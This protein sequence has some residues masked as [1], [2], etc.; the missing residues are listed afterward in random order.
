MSA[1][2]IPSLPLLAEL[3]FNPVLF[4]SPL[5]F[6]RTHTQAHT[7][8]LCTL[9]SALR[10]DRHPLASTLICFAS[11]F[12]KWRERKWCG[13]RGLCER[14]R[15]RGGGESCRRRAEGHWKKRSVVGMR[16]TQRKEDL[17]NVVGWKVEGNMRATLGDRK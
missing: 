10:N 5:L 13:G 9:T 12:M 2:L 6:I 11:S 4:F 7:H 17:G 16:S 3:P 14:G 15:G 8:S 1:Q